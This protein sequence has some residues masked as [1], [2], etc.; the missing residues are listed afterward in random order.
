MKKTLKK[1]VSKRHAKDPK[2]TP[3]AEA[4]VI[5]KKATSGDGALVK[6]PGSDELVQCPIGRT[7][8]DGV[9]VVVTP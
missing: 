4:V 7:E 6:L 5:T 8:F 1:T 3:E 9:V 2:V